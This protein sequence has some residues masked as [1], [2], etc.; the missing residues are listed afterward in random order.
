MVL[1][2]LVALAILALVNFYICFR[3]WQ[4]LPPHSAWRTG[5]LVAILFFSL[6]FVAGRL[7]ERVWLSPLSEALT[8]IGSYWLAAML[9]FFLAVL[10]IDILR[11]LLLIFPVVP[12]N[13]LEAVRRER[14]WILVGTVGLVVLLLV[15]GHL[16]AAFPR[17]RELDLTLER[18]LRNGSLRVVAATDIHLGTIIGRQRCDRIVQTINRL[19]PDLVLL[20]GD[21]VDE[22]LGPVIRENLGESLRAIR[23]RYGVFAVTGNHEYIGGADEA[24]RYLEEHGIRVLRDSVVTL[25]DGLQIVGR[26][27]RAM[28]QFAG[29][30]R[31]SLNDLLS[32]LDS[33]KPVLMMDHQPFQLEEVSRAGVDVQ[34]SGHTHHGQIWPLN[35]ITGAMYEISRGYRRIGR[36]HFY[37]SSGA[38]TWGPPVRLGNTPEI[39]LLTLHSPDS[40]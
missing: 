9:Y 28:R 4:A 26:E 25:P 18:P 39:V 16:N 12:E 3:G 32:G 29:R 34:L 37:V 40:P 23:A 24:C 8:W 36:T 13:V 15:A 35:Y 7:L 6:S 14:H 38:G 22:D 19:E 20:P 30:A 1:F 33:S 10:A 27:D 11:L 5:F 2:F 21:V 17:V 31:K